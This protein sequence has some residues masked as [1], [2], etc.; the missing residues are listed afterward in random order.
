MAGYAFANP[1]YANGRL[2]ATVTPAQT[3]DVPLATA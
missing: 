2:A 1:P 3:R